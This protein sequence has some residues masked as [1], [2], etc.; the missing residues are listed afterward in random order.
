VVLAWA[1]LL[2][3]YGAAVATTGLGPIGVLRALVGIVADHPA[4]PLVFVLAY[5]LR[6]LF[7]FSATVLTIGAG[8][9]YGPWLG[10]LVVLV[11]ANGGALLAYGLARWLGGPWATRALDGGRWGAL[12]ARLRERTFE[13]VLTLRFLFA[14]YDAV[15]YLAG[16]LRLRPVPFVLATALGSIPG[17]FTFL[18]FGASIGD[19]SV[20]ADG[21]L[22]ALDGRALVV[23]AALFVASLLASRALRRRVARREAGAGPAREPAS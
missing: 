15:N 4:G 22:P 12:A 20:L 8:H 2:V 5:V 17:S 9:L 6:P 16:A 21:R 1:A 7:V 3:A 19:L 10:F 14:P 18:L 13:T 23:S 11:G